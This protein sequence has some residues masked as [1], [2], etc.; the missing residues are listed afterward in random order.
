MII[1]PNSLNFQT[2]ISSACSVTGPYPVM[3]HGPGAK[4]LIF[5]FTATALKIVSPIHFR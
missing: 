1:K 4:P 2:K 5:V 3:N